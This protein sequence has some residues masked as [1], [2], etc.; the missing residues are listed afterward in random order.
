MFLHFLSFLNTE[1]VSTIQTMAADDLA[2]QGAT[3]QFIS[4]NDRDLAVNAVPKYHRFSIRVLFGYKDVILSVQQFPF[5]DNKWK[6][7]LKLHCTIIMFEINNL[8]SKLKSIFRLIKPLTRLKMDLGLILQKAWCLT[9]HNANMEYLLW[10]SITC[11]P[12]ATHGPQNF[13]HQIK[14]YN[15]MNKTH[16]LI[17]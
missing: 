5:T 6:G 1:R 15:Y 11:L 2:M 12:S 14:Q 7:H 8:K 13:R 4:S 10:H 16:H 9:L 17:W 3:L